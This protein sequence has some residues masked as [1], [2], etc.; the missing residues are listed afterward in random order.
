[1]TAAASEGVAPALEGLEA[2]TLPDGVRLVLV[3]HGE[4]DWNMVRRI[5]GQLDEPLNAVGVQQAKAA[6]A[7][8][9][10]GMVDAIHC[11]DLLRASQ[12]AAEIGAVTGVPV[13][14]EAFWRER[15]FGRFQGWVYA[16]IQRD[17]P[18]TYRRIEARD[19]DLDLQGGESLMQVRA[20]IEAALA[21][22]V[23]R[24]RGQRVVVVSHG[25]V[26]DAIYR[27]V[28][29]KP[30]SEP[31]DFLI[32]N[33]CICQLRWQAG[34]WEI[35]QWAD[36]AHLVASRDEIDPRQRPAALLGRIG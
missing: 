9:A 12:T 31:R 14:P 7:R 26:L 6:A 4:T 32:H 34:R 36:I 25:G 22:L 2:G 15:H 24:Y 17:D 8:F 27:L 18:E 35:L 13:V 30:V 20:R 1:M 19:P 23:Q 29:G 10:P 33:A 16:D 11:S 3:R 28:T 21:G 5:Q